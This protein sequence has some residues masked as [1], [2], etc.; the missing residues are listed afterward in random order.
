MHFLSG[1]RNAWDNDEYVMTIDCSGNVG[2]GTDSPVALLNPHGTAALT[3]ADQVVLISDSNAD[4][5]IGRGGNLGFA[6]YVNGSMRTLAAI[7]GLKT[8]AGNSFNG[9]LGLYTRV[10]GQAELAERSYK[11]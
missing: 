7:G 4:D 1:N 10:N 6:G 2:V 5:A 8:N 3:N 11:I 9:D